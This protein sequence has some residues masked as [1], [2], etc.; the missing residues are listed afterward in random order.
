MTAPLSVAIAQI[1]LVVGDINGNLAKIL[2]TLA[3]ARDELGSRLV[4]FPELTITGY[5][6]ED[7]L[8]RPAFVDAAMG[9]VDI[10]VPRVVG[11]AA[12]VGHP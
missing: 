8:L 6:P 10:L 3:R 11:I 9:A 7:L 4:V 12:V 1:N 2:R 5:P